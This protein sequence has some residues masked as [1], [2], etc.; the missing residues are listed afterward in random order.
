MTDNN[1]IVFKVEERSYK[2][3]IIGLSITFFS[4]ML[5]LS[6][7]IIITVLLFTEPPVQF[8]YILASI[9]LI[10]TGI[11]VVILTIN[12]IYKICEI[13]NDSIFSI[14]TLFFKSNVK[15]IDLRNIAF[16]INWDNGLEIAEKSVKT[17]TMYP[18]TLTKFKAP[19]IRRY[20]YIKLHFNEKDPMEN[21]QM[22]DILDFLI[23]QSNLINHP[24]FDFIYLSQ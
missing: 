14:P 19:L 10:I 1:N 23:K 9:L 7:F 15:Q 21:R 16:V 6:I 8:F 11:S 4:I 20:N 5:L 24:N 18:E 2:N 3:T 17:S 12:D 22:K 13:T